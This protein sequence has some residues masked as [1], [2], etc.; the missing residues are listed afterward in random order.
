V[1]I[2]YLHHAAPLA[3]VMHCDSHVVKMSLETAQILCTVHHIHGNGEN[4]P[5]KSTHI[6]HPSVIWAAE[7]KVQYMWLQNLGVYLCREY[8]VRYG[9]RHACEKYINGV[10]SKPPEALIKGKYLW[11]EPPQAMP[12]DCKVEGD[13]ITAY[14]KYYQKHKSS[15]AKWRIGGVP[16]FMLGCYNEHASDY[17]KEVQFA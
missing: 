4:V 11:R 7:S 13:A 12:D 6:H 14:R 15:F 17:L 1:N 9:R 8:Y 5:Y 16:A 3:A 10:L 2:F